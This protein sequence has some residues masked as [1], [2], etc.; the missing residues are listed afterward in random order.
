M[1]LMKV[2]LVGKRE[3]DAF[4]Q[5]HGCEL[6]DAGTVAILER[7]KRGL[8]ADGRPSSRDLALLSFVTLLSAQRYF[9][10]SERLLKTCRESEHTGDYGLETLVPLI[11]E[12]CE[13]LSFY[14]GIAMAERL[15]LSDSA[16]VEVLTNRL[17]AAI[18]VHD[19]EHVRRMVADWQDQ[20]TLA[21]LQS[22][23]RDPA[24][25]EPVFCPT[26]RQFVT[27]VPQ[28]YC[29]FAPQ[30]KYWGADEWHE[31][32]SL[33]DNVARFARGLFRF[34]AVAKKEKFKG[35][36][37]RLPA[38]MSDS[39]ERLAETTATLLAGLNRI[40]PASSLCLEQPIGEEG[41]KFEWAGETIFLT[42][43]GTCYPEKHPRNP[44]GF[45]YTYFFIQ[46]DFVLRAH[47]MM[48]DENEA[49]T[50]ARILAN[51]NKHGMSFSNE[52]K[53]AESERYVRPMEA[54]DPPI[55]W[56]DYLPQ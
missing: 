56:W 43:F 10:H 13:T 7:V 4:A 40:D 2:F 55:R 35:F 29:I 20:E 42:A 25:Y 5:E 12:L 32:E 23:A 50:R 21:I 49:K 3:S 46:P 31:N 9:A 19:P 28:T 52:N 38:S 54:M 11:D 34:L 39:I 48:S 18:A 27:A 37:A 36:A 26:F 16:S 53:R 33:E 44:H 15:P 51:F 24:G 45:D 47:P 22:V 1:N 8:A 14:A 30:G 6:D 41:W 17:F